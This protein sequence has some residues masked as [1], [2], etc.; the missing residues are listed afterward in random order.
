MNYQKNHLK[1]FSKIIDL[2]TPSEYHSNDYHFE[3]EVDFWL[4]EIYFILQGCQ[5]KLL[6]IRYRFARFNM[7]F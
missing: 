6:F 3:V 7:K 5:F 2:I 1:S 4:T